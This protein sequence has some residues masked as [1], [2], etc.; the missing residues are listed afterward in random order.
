M[1]TNYKGEE[2][3]A[4]FDTTM[5]DINSLLMKVFNRTYYFKDYH[6]LILEVIPYYCKNPITL[7]EY[8]NELC[9]RGK[10]TRGTYIIE[11]Q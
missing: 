6:C 3:P 4:Y 8:L 11:R 10:L 1:R 9:L 7:E 5:N 2:I